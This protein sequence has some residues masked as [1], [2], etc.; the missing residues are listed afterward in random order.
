MKHIISTLQ[1]CIKQAPEMEGVNA[2]VK[3]QVHVSQAPWVVESCEHYYMALHNS[4]NIRVC[5]TL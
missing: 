3:S 2:Q 4:V 1:I 5:M